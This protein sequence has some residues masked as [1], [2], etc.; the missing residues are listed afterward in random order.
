MP[1][2]KVVV[3]FSSTANI[4]MAMKVAPEDTIRHLL[5]AVLKKVHAKGVGKLRTEMNTGIRRS[6]KPKAK[7]GS[8]GITQVMYGRDDVIPASTLVL[9]V[10]SEEEKE[11][12]ILKV[13]LAAVATDPLQA[14]DLPFAQLDQ[15]D[16]V[17]TDFPTE[18][19]CEHKED[20]EVSNTEIDNK[21]AADQIC[22][23]KEKGEV[24]IPETNDNVAE[25]MNLSARACED[26]P[27]TA[28]SDSKAL[29][30]SVA[31]KNAEEASQFGKQR[32]RRQ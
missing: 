2:V 6:D 12:A 32:E 26:T 20:E 22:E 7:S 4:T 9:T 10:F 18:A 15:A 1:I 27:S 16:L 5:L 21:L 29:P 30:K 24:L 17:L 23:H 14:R 25:R 31:K 3:Q 28:R 8:V 11:S 19:L 13:P